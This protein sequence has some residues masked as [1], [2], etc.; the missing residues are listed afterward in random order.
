MEV[1][2]VLLIDEAGTLHMTPQMAARVELLEPAT[3]VVLS[4]A[5]AAGEPPR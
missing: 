2:H 4:G 3:D 5:P 1:D